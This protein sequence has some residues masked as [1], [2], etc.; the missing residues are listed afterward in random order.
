MLTCIVLASIDYYNL[1]FKCIST[2]LIK[3]FTKH[4]QVPLEKQEGS[5]TSLRCIKN[6]CPKIKGRRRNV[7]IFLSMPQFKF[8]N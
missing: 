1:N 3:L 2:I 5:K 6:W 8:S 7:Q 4:F